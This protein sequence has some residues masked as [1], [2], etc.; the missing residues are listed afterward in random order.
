MKKPVLILSSDP[1]D[2]GALLTAAWPPTSSAIAIT[3]QRYVEEV[4]IRRSGGECSVSPDLPTVPCVL[5][6]GASTEMGD[7]QR[8]LEEERTSCLLSALALT[9]AAVVNRPTRYSP[10]GLFSDVPSACFPRANLNNSLQ[11]PREIF[12]G[13]RFRR[14]ADL[15]NYWMLDLGSGEVRPANSKTRTDGTFRCVEGCVDPS[16]ELVY[17]AGH[18]VWRESR[19]KLFD[20]DLLRLSKEIGDALGLQL[21][22]LT[23]RFAESKYSAPSLIAVDPW[24]PV[25]VVSHEIERIACSIE[26]FLT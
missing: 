13:G 19:A 25:N 7:A 16:Y 3:S 23:W 20:A 5:E 21:C 17:I 14:L 10:V 18:D 9:R 8:F 15:K 11:W 2:L 4:T 1:N 26:K 22:T 6:H 12:V 24:P